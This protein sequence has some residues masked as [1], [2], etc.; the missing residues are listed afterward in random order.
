L[1]G[2]AFIGA[3]LTTAPDG[4]AIGDIEIKISPSAN[5]GSE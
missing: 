3:L 2:I 1:F 4:I 5:G